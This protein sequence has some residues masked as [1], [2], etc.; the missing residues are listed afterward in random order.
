MF[1]CSASLSDAAPVNPMLLSVDLMRMEKSELLMNAICVQFL[2]YLLLKLRWVSVVLDFNTSL[3]DVAPLIPMLFPVD[4]MRMEKS[5][6]LMDVICVVSFVLT[7]QIEF[8][9][10][11]V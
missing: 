10:C 11:F 1:D 6:L 7:I 2:L 5:E 4:L 8:R 9:E 3:S